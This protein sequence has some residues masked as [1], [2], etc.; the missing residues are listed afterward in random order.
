MASADGWTFYLIPGNEATQEIVGETRFL[1]KKDRKWTLAEIIQSREAALQEFDLK[2]YS[3][4]MTMNFNSRRVA[5]SETVLKQLGEGDHDIYLYLRK[6]QAGLNPSNNGSKDSRNKNK[7]KKSGDKSGDKSDEEDLEYKWENRMDRMFLQ[8]NV[9][10]RLQL[11]YNDCTNKKTFVQFLCI[12]NIIDSEF[13]FRLQHE[14]RAFKIERIKEEDGKIRYK[15]ICYC[16]G[17]GAEGTEQKSLIEVVISGKLRVGWHHIQQHIFRA[18]KNLW[19]RL[20]Y[21]YVRY[22]S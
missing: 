21:V 5:V 11:L 1:D 7:D 4:S 13:V 6:Q 18:D 22:I 15:L 10:L 20:W 9:L 16:K 2:Q 8:K 19:K 17:C 3:I 14:E 12:L